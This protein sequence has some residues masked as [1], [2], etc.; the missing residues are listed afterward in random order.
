MLPDKQSDLGEKQPCPHIAPDLE[1]LQEQV[2]TFFFLIPFVTLE[3]TH[4]E[5]TIMFS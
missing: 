5:A 3:G 4:Y 1:H 2:E